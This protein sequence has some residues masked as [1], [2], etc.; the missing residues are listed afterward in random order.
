MGTREQDLAKAWAKKGLAEGPRLERAL[1]LVGG[2]SSQGEGVWVVEGGQRDYVV[3]LDPERQEPST[4][5]CPDYV[6]RKVQCKHQL[7]ALLVYWAERGRRT[8]EKKG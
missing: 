7:A 2:V 4:C 1:A 8:P 5:D 3:F 6:H